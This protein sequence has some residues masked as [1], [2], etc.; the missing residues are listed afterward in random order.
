MGIDAIPVGNRVCI[1]GYNNDTQLVNNMNYC[2]Y[3]V[4]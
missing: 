1:E 4:A 2:V 3:A